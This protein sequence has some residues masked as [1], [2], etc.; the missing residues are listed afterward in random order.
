MPFWL[1]NHTETE[2]K[3]NI[4]SAKNLNAKQN[5]GRTEEKLHQ[6]FRGMEG[7][8]SRSTTGRCKKA[9]AKSESLKH[10]TAM[11][12]DSR[13]CFLTLLRRSMASTFWAVF[14]GRRAASRSKVLRNLLSELFWRNS[15]TWKMETKTYFLCRGYSNFY[16][17]HNVTLLKNILRKGPELSD[18]QK[19]IIRNPV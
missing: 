7:S 13:K 1:W 17:I 3:Q 11:R 16:F 10:G 4:P 9:T 15:C 5:K 14:G 8:T 18:Q 12:G 2:L 6:S 19:Q